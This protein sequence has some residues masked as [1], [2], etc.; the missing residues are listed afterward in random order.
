MVSL[1]E[2]IQKDKQ[3][4]KGQKPNRNVWYFL[5]FSNLSGTTEVTK[6]STE[7]PS[8]NNAA[9][10]RT[11][12]VEKVVDSDRTAKKEDHED[13]LMRKDKTTFKK[14]EDLTLKC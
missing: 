10:E 6:N 8:I 2:E 4:H 12:E 1:D 14:L 9:L 13:S 11:P 3:K 7:V 5:I